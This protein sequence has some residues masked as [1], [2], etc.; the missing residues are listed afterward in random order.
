MDQSE[1]LRPVSESAV[2]DLAG[3]PEWRR[4]ELANIADEQLTKWSGDAE[5]EAGEL[6]PPKG[7]QKKCSRCGQ[8]G[9]T[10]PRCDSRD[11]GYMLGALG[12]LPGQ[13]EER[14][15]ARQ[16]QA[17]ARVSKRKAAASD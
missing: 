16:K 11:I 9:H 2:S 13:A 6:P 10:A 17:L 7:R 1:E 4:K 8:L 15:V 3:I 12:V 14:A 5:A